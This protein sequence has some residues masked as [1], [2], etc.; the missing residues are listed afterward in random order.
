MVVLLVA[1]ELEA[2][3]LY[4]DNHFQQT[5]TQLQ[6]EQVV[7]VEQEVDFLEI[8]HLFQQTE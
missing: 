5:L 7:H 3:E 1:V 8:A 2:L 4:Q 6:L